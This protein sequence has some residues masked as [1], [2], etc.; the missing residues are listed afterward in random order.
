MFNVNIKF[1]KYHLLFYYQVLNEM[2][3]VVY[4]V[5]VSIYVRINFQGIKTGGNFAIVLLFF[6]E[7]ILKNMPKRHYSDSQCPRKRS[8][9]D[10]NAIIYNT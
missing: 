4:F 8:N 10:D 9:V 3:N 2:K 6:W 1:N 7:K 5:L